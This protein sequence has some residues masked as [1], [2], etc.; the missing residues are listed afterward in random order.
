MTPSVFVEL[1]ALP[2][3]PNGKVDRKALPVPT[4][5][6]PEDLKSDFVAARTEVEQ[7]LVD[8]WSELLGVGRVG[9]NN[10]FF[11]LGGHSL[12]AMQINARIRSVLNTELPLST[13]FE[14]PTIREVAE[15]I[16]HSE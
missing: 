4:K 11:E 3:T 8:I 9:I 6:R 2:L 14:L 5:G 12:I 13:L 1:D 16:A 10:N 7:K 15:V